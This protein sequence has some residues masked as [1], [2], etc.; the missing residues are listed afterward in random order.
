M[1]DDSWPIEMSKP[2]Q[3]LGK[4]SRLQQFTRLQTQLGARLRLPP[5]LALQYPGHITL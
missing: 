3:N 1:A 4:E 5:F 2:K